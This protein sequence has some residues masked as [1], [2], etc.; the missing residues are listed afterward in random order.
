M[1]VGMSVVSSH[2]P[3]LDLMERAL[4]EWALM[5]DLSRPSVRFE[6]EP[7]LR[8]GRQAIPAIE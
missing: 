3:E 4:M 2:L 7:K 6:S 1:T 8:P 5:D